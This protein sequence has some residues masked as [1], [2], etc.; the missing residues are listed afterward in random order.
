MNMG[1]LI[2]EKVVRSLYKGL[3]LY[4]ISYGVLTDVQDHKNDIHAWHDIPI[5]HFDSILSWE[6]VVFK[7]SNWHGLENGNRG[8]G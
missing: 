8:F 7:R 2:R 1:S 3:L 4:I 6:K 5:L